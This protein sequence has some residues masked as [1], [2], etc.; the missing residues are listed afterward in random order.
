MADL[1]KAWCTLLPMSAASTCAPGGSS[2]WNQVIL[3]LPIKKGEWMKGHVGGKSRQH[4]TIAGFGIGKSPKESA[5]VV[6]LESSN[7]M[8]EEAWLTSKDD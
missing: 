5:G 6:H 1:R 7:A 3:A 2:R 4:T 8:G